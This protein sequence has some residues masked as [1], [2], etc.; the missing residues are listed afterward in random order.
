MAVRDI[1]DIEQIERVPLHARALP[2]NTLQVFDERA[3]KTPDAPALTFFLDA[4]RLDRS[5]TWTFAELRADI[6]RT[7]NVLASVGI[8]A[9]DVAAFVLP[10]LP[11]TH[12]A[13]WGGEAAGIA[14]AINPLLD[15]AQIAELVDAARAKVLICVAPTPGVDIWPKLAPHLDAMPTVETVIWVDLRPYVSLPKRAAL[16]WIERREKAR[17]RGARVRIV[18]LHAEMR[19]Q[20]GDRLIRP[21]A[22]GPDEPSSYFC[23]GGTTGRPKIAVRTHGSEVFDVW[24]ASETQARDD[25]GARTVFCGLPLFHVNGQLVTGLMAW[26]R[27]H[28][29]VLG[30]PQGYRGKNV[31]ARFWAIVEAYRIN[32]FSGVP[33]LFAALLQQPVGRHDIGSLEYAACGAAPMPVELAR[34]FE[35]TTGVKIVEGYGLTES[36]CI[37]SLNPLDGERRIGSI[38]LRLPYQR[39]RAVIVDD[40]GRYVRD[41]LVDEV[42]LIALAGPNVFRG[43]LDPAHERGLWI[44]IAGERWLNT[45]DLGRRDAHGYFWLVGRKKELIIR[46]GHNIDPRII[47]DALTAHPAVALAAAIGRPDAHAGELP[48]AYVQ[49]KAGASADEAALLAFAADAIAERAAVPKH[50]RILEAVPTTAVGKIFKPQLQRL[51]IA[52]VVAACARDAQV[53]LE[54]VDVVQDARRGLVAQ[55]AVRGAREALAE[56]LARYAFPVDWSGD[57]AHARASEAQRDAAAARERAS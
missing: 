10:N 2:A 38:G 12:F 28:H 5:H 18:N 53:A 42:G 9:G 11:D 3:A 17:L 54:R 21:R 14:M 30:T 24:A 47:E 39:M 34:S 43:Y 52:D 7:A 29:V 15:G 41:A 48:V 57:G 4:G 20:P 55:V 25:E 37:A 31:I 40:T 51:E 8:G 33:T 1:H 49:L 32:A 46:G 56:R 26:L 50:V 23:T 36:A 44:D 19:R 22:I 35:R 6:V 45:G 13:I 27:G 16:A